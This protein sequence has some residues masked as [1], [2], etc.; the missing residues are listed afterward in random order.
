M[1]KSYFFIPT[2]S[3]IG[4]FLIIFFYGTNIRSQTCINLP[5]NFESYSQASSLINKSTFKLT[6]KLPTGKSSWIISAKFLSC[7]GNYGYLVYRTEKGNEYIHE[8]IPY[9]VWLEFKNAS[10]SGSYYNSFIK[11]RYR[12]IPY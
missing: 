6:D 12:L 7:D 3:I 2:P 8:N 9:K 4:I 10:S 5:S 1:V 11:G